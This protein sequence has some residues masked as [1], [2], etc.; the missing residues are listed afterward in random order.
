MCSPGVP[1]VAIVFKNFALWDI[2]KM[3]GSSQVAYRQK[4]SF[5]GFKIWSKVRQNVGISLSPLSWDPCTALL[6]NYCTDLL[7]MR[8]EDSCTTNKSQFDSST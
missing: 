7:S 1:L 2:P 8:I 5:V 3:H 4:N 6:G